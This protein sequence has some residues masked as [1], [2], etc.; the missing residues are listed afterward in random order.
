MATQEVQHR[1][2]N[3]I[4]AAAVLAAGIGSFVLG[5]LT[6]LAAVS[7]GLA[8]MLN[9]YNPAGP[10]SGKSGLAVIAW[11][12]SWVILHTR[13]KD[14]EVNFNQIFVITLIL[15]GLGLLLT[16]P[17]IFEAFE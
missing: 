14:K 1:L 11:L 12:V 7:E 5:L 15:I 13:W 16:F 8:Q 3:G 6:T 9:W 4:A 2:A 17:P 10:L